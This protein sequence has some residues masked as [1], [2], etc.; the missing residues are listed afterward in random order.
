MGIALYTVSKIFE[1]TI[2]IVLSEERREKIK[3]YIFMPAMVF[4]TGN[5]IRVVRAWA[6]LKEL[7]FRSS[8]KDSW[9]P[10]K[11]SQQAKQLDI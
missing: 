8:Y 11:T 10:A 2:V 6:Y 9:N 3:Y 7:I 5:F 1:F 4:Y